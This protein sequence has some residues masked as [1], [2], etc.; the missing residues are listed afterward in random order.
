MFDPETVVSDNQRNIFESVEER[1]STS[2]GV[3]GRFDCH[4]DG[5]HLTVFQ[6]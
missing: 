2:S 6:Q 3:R 4:P 1:Y 5:D